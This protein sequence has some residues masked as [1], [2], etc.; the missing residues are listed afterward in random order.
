MLFNLVFSRF[1]AVFYDLSSLGNFY[2]FSVDII[3]LLFL[4][5]SCTFCMYTLCSL[6]ICF[7]NIFIFKRWWKQQY[8]YRRYISIIVIIIIIIVIIYLLLFWVGRFYQH[9][10]LLLLLLLFIYSFIFYCGR[11]ENPAILIS[12]LVVITHASNV[13]RQHS[14]G[15]AL[16]MN[17]MHRTQFDHARLVLPSLVIWSCV[18][19]PSVNVELTQSTALEQKCF[20]FRSL[21]PPLR[22]L[23]LLLVYFCFV[24]FCFAVNIRPLALFHVCLER[25]SFYTALTVTSILLD[26]ATTAITSPTTGR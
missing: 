7:L 17:G 9:Q 19:W 18:F 23:W 8:W 26:P 2:S 24:L 4:V 14:F 13:C 3:V 16:R 25:L 20:D 22:N 11:Q 6:S 15:L 5:G 12:G 1:Y 21:S 10:P